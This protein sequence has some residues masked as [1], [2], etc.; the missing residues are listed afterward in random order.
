MSAHI[1]G[2]ISV[3]VHADSVSDP[4]KKRDAWVQARQCCAAAAAMQRLS[5][6]A[7]D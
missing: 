5:R 2:S 7:A 3:I 6:L 1:A 4:K